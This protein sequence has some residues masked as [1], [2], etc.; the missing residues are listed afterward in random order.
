MQREVNGLAF[1]S[2]EGNGQFRLSFSCRIEQLQNEFAGEDSPA[3][4]CPWPLSKRR[5]SAHRDSLRWPLLA[6]FST[7]DG[8]EAWVL[9]VLFPWQ[10]KKQRGTEDA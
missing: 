3:A 8:T 9:S 2:L 6:L 5:D 10:H 1:V 4:L 7:Y